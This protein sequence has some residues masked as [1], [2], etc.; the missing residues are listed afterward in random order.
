MS[1]LSRQARQIPNE[2]IV[3]VDPC[4]KL[5][6]VD[7]FVGLMSGER[8][9]EK[10]ANAK[11]RNASLTGKAAVGDGKCDGWWTSHISESCRTKALVLRLIS[12]KVRMLIFYLQFR[13]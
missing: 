3:S 8:C 12:S 6:F 7:H 1:F 2:N 5:T 4:Q 13:A 9:V 11:C 10:R